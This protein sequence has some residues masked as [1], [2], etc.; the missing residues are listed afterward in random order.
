MEK[1]A[2][3]RRRN[4][5]L[6]AAAYSTALVAAASAVGFV[7]SLTER[8]AP[9]PNLHRILFDELAD[10]HFMLTVTATVVVHS[11]HRGRAALRL[12]CFPSN[13]SGI[14]KEALWAAHSS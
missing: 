10:R 7:D 4:R 12:L 13:I 14:P 8:A 11:Q 5:L 6:R 1:R 2:I 9:E 3:E